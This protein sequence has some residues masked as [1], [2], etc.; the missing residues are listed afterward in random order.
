MENYIEAINIE[1]VEDKG[2]AVIAKQEIKSGTLVLKGTFKVTCYLDEKPIPVYP[3]PKHSFND[4]S[5]PLQFF[6]HSCAPN[7]EF[8]ANIKASKPIFTLEGNFTTYITQ[9]QT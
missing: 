4:H 3:W 2:F 6:N 8:L 5:A 1:K 9:T 7:A